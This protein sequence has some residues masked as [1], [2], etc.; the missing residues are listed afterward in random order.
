M[1]DYNGQMSSHARTDV[2]SPDR[3]RLTQGQMSSHVVSCRLMSSH[4]VSCRLTQTDVVSHTDRCRLTHRQM[5]SHIDIIFFRE[6]TDVVSPDRC[7]LTGQMSS[8]TWTDVVS[9]DRCRLTQGQMSSHV[10][11]CR[12][13]SSHVVSCRLTQEQMSAHGHQYCYF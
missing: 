12:L 2:V 7:R 1:Y 8:H 4:V 9:P 3:C 5:Y 13:M 11:S 10:V 6:P